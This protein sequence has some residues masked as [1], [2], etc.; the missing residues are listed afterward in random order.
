MRGAEVVAHIWGPSFDFGAARAL[1]ALVRQ[2]IAATAKG[3]PIPRDD[4]RPADVFDAPEKVA[5]KRLAIARHL[6]ESG[7]P[8]RAVWERCLALTNAPTGRVAEGALALLLGPLLE[9][10]GLDTLR[11]VLFRA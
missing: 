2:E 9:P 1:D 10:N 11:R 8:E 7:Q 3:N 5:A 4:S 6:L